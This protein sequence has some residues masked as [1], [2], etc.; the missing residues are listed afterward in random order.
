MMVYIKTRTQQT[1][2]SDKQLRLVPGRNR[3]PI[4]LGHRPLNLETAVLALV[5]SSIAAAAA[6]AGLAAASDAVVGV[7]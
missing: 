6:Y 2:S 5:C 1:S 3:N 4:R 7:Y